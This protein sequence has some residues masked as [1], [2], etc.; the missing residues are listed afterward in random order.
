M[1]L[2][3]ELCVSILQLNLLI[4]MMTR[5]YE[6]ISNTTDEYKRQVSGRGDGVKR[7]ESSLSV[8]ESRVDVGGFSHSSPASSLYVSILDPDRNK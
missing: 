3:F 5:T 7:I 8:G 6:A 1:F 4:A 2:F